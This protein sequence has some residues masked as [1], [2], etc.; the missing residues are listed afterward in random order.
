MTAPRKLTNKQQIF[1][2]EYLI[3]LNATAAYKR[4][5]YKA[6]GNAAEAAASRLLRNVKVAAAVAAAQAERAERVG[7]TADEVLREL[8][9]LGRSDVWHYEI[10]DGG[11]VRLA[12]GAPPE[13]IR[14][15]SSI[16]RKVKHTDTGTE[17]ETEIKLWSKPDALRMAAQHL[18]LLVDKTELTVKGPPFKVYAGFD[19]HEAVCDEP[20]QPQ[21]TTSPPTDAPTAPAA[22]PASSSPAEPP[23]SS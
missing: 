8:A 19:P 6:G 11:R 10:N 17:V 5:G 1:V 13:A 21:P 3:D 22:P 12:E 15:V 16:K 18:G 14:A 7:L 4:A 23:R 9:V 20:P 2:R